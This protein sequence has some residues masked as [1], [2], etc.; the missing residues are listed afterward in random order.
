MRELAETIIHLD[1]VPAEGLSL[2]GAVSAG[3][4]SRLA[5]AVARLDRPVEVDLRL[6]P[7]KDVFLL[8]GRV[9]G[10][11]SLECEGCRGVFELPL[12]ERVFLTVDPN[13]ERALYRDPT[14]KG[15]VWV[16]DHSDEQVEAPD[17]VF[18]L[19]GALE[20]EWI[21]E[22]PLSPRCREGCRGICPVCGANRNEAECGCPRPRP[23]SPFDVLA[24][25]KKDE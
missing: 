10:R 9:T 12:A 19:I 13:P 5:G 20:D 18:D 2:V 15:E 4:L 17:G 11:V 8:S 25:L 16:L 24:Q 21:L 7:E 3:R 14:Q 22:L 23:E 1:Q 6:D